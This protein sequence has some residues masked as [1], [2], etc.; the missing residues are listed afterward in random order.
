MAELCLNKGCSFAVPL[1]PHRGASNAALTN[2]AVRMTPYPSSLAFAQALSKHIAHL[3]SRDP[4]VIVE[5]RIEEVDDDKEV[6]LRDV[7]CR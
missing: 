6:R 2:I 4:L 5:G 7:R 3:I 1:S